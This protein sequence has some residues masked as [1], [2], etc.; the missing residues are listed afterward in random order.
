[1]KISI[2]KDL[3]ITLGVTIIALLVSIVLIRVKAGEYFGLLQ[4][5]G[6]DMTTEEYMYGGAFIAVVIALIGQSLMMFAFPLIATAVLLAIFFTV[7]LIVKDEEKQS[8]VVLIFLIL[9]VPF[10][11]ATLLTI[12]VLI[13]LFVAFTEATT[14]P[15]LSGA[16][17][18]FLG[19]S[20]LCLIGAVITE[21]SAYVKLRKRCKE[22]ENEQVV[23]QQ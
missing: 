12:A 16:I 23:A 7:L 1:M 19:I 11:I 8:R 17:I 2:K 20:A 21:I 18:V 15:A 4:Q 22:L 5:L 6:Q 9:S 3:A 13:Y 10:V 14:T